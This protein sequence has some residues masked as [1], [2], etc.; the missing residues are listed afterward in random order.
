MLDEH[1]ERRDRRGLPVHSD[2][3]GLGEDEPP[4]DRAEP[5]E[6]HAHVPTVLL[7]Q[8]NLAPFQQANEPGRYLIPARIVRPGA[9][10]VA[11]VRPRGR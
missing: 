2:L 11:L 4:I 10:L 7:D 8:A 6:S 5:V 9:K 3:N 1:V